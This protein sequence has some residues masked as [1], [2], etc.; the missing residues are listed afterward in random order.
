[1]VEIIKIDQK[2]KKIEKI[3][4]FL[5]KIK[6]VVDKVFYTCYIKRAASEITKTKRL[7]NSKCL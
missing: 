6:K 7:G 5:K 1:M 4:K 2:S 3:R